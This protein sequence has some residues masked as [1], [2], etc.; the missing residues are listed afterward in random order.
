VLILVMLAGAACAIF[1][2][3]HRTPPKPPP[4][5][6]STGDLE[7][8]LGIGDYAE[9]VNVAEQRWGRSSKEYQSAVR[10]QADSLREEAELAARAAIRQRNW[11]VAT[12]ELTDA[13]PGAGI[14]RGRELRAAIRLTRELAQ[15]QDLEAKGKL[16]DAL[17]LYT[18]NAGLV[19]TLEG[20]LGEQ[21][22]RLR[23]LLERAP[24]K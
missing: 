13:L 15:A 14:E 23:K 1:A 5:A 24:S 6:A 2:V 10:R 7:V 22:S 20:Y 17:H 8:L 4:P 19:P 16:E 12:K 3:L 21:I 11:P 18:H 9:A